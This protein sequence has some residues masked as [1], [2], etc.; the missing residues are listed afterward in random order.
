M[1]FSGQ[2]PSPST[3]RPTAAHSPRSRSVLHVLPRTPRL[4]IDCICCAP[5]EILEV[6]E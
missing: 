4:I 1:V 5:A 6:Y 2:V 3:A